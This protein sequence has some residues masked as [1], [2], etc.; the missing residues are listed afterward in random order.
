MFLYNDHSVISALVAGGATHEEAVENIFFG[1]NRNT[2]LNCNYNRLTDFNPLK[3][4]LNAV[5]SSIDYN[6]TCMD[7]IF[8]NLE[9]SLADQVRPQI[10]WI[11][12]QRERKG[13]HWENALLALDCFV[14]GPV[15]KGINSRY[16]GIDRECVLLSMAFIGST[17]NTL[18]AIQKLVFDGDVPM[19][20]LQ[21]ALS[22]NFAG[23]EK[24]R[25][26][27]LDLEKYGQDVE[28]VDKLGCRL[29]DLV[30][31]TTMSI[32]K[33]LG[34]S[35]TFVLVHSLQTD[36]DYWKAF[37]IGATPDGR[38]AGQPTSQN[39]SPVDGT[40]INGLTA[41]LNSV[42]RVTK[43]RVASGAN[44]ISISK[45]MVHDEHGKQML[46]QLLKVYFDKGGIQAQLSVADVDEMKD[47]QKSPDQHRDLMVR[48]T[49]YSAC[50]V[51]MTED[52][53]AS[54]IRREN[55]GS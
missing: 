45:S 49:G 5:N 37:D 48:I 36:T 55:Y 8:K 52:A 21:T 9:K 10:Q 1:C 24:L 33:E 28:E 34:V 26:R 35:D 23:Y 32:I 25:K 16:K 47:A 20:I 43:E 44:N 19:A 22:T 15:E 50:F 13:G 31:S 38:L 3:S 40:A 14:N 18:Y 53:Q 51:D 42:A 54:V 11:I 29:I 2:L 41:M 17:I 39:A 30:F 46:A 12:D 4:I 7:D 6:L 27:M